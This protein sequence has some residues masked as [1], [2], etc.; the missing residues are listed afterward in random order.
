[1][2]ERIFYKRSG[3]ILNGKQHCGVESVAVGLVGGFF[4]NG[5]GG[6]R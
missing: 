6:N 3:Q 2:L 4:H 1:M 5:R